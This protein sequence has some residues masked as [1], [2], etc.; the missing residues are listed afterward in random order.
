MTNAATD[1]HWAD[2]LVLAAVLAVSTGIGFYT[3]CC[4]KGQRTTSEYLHGGR[5]LQLF[6]VSM[7]VLASFLSAVSVLGTPLEVYL[8][9]A[10]FALFTLSFFISV[11][12][13]AHVF[14]PFFYQ[15]KVATVYEYLELRFGRL[16][17]LMGS[18]VFSLQMVFYMAIVLYAP[19]LALSQVS[20]LSTHLSIVGLGIVCTVYTVMGGL[21]AVVYT[22]TFQV[23]IIL[24]GVLMLIIKGISDVGGF[25][26]MWRRASN[27]GRLDDVINSVFEPSLTIR[28][29]FWS[30]T[31]GGAITT[32]SVY[33]INQTIVQRYLAVRKLSHAQRAAYLNLPANVFMTLL[34]CLLGLVAY[35]C[36]VHCDPYLTGRIKAFDQL[37]LVMVMDVLGS[38]PGLP[39]LFLACIFSASLSTVSSGVNALALVFLE[40]FV[41][42]TYTAIRHTAMTDELSI[43]ISKTL[44][45]TFGLVTVAM[46]YVTGTMDQTLVQITFMSFGMTGGPLLGL[47]LLAMFCPCANAWGAGVGLLCSLSFSFWIGIGAIVDGPRRTLL[48]LTSINCSRNATPILMSFVTYNITTTSL[49]TLNTTFTTQEATLLS[50]MTSSLDENPGYD[51]L[52]LYQ[53]SYMWYCVGSSSLVITIGLIISLLTGCSVHEE[54]HPEL[55]VPLWQN[56]KTFIIRQKKNYDVWKTQKAEEEKEEQ[57]K[58]YKISLEDE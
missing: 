40:D 47:F 55:V 37:I 12:L 25:E 58:D 46:A 56:L 18:S 27:G 32:L 14:I 39:G 23:F 10:S 8:N 6:P 28:H 52:A 34:L 13:T 16:I 53:L 19:A 45:L 20:N 24:S 26:E 54:I 1:F 2:Y 9:G 48:P 33:G 38:Y 36:Y 11:P 42:P 29:T 15:L 31:I 30:L 50:D 43:V 3:A 5:Q 7:S 49:T 17:R 41:K 57:K 22:D 21:R 4:L 44:A 51:G 35:A